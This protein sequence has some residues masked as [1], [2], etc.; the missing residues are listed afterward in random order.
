[1]EKIYVEWVYV[2]NYYLDIHLNLFKFNKML[3]YKMVSII[4]IFYSHFYEVL[5]QR[6]QLV[7][8]TCKPYRFWGFARAYG[9]TM[10]SLR[11]L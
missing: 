5:A 8:F 7:R 2:Y 6:C 10:Q 3:V 1:M 4:F 11:Y 9:R